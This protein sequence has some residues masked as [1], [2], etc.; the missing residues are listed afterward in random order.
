MISIPNTI[1]LKDEKVLDELDSSSSAHT[2]II[3]CFEDSCE[4][5]FEQEIGNDKNYYA[6][7]KKHR[8]LCFED[9][10]KWGFEKGH[11]WHEMFF[12]DENGIYVCSNQINLSDSRFGRIHFGE[13]T[14]EM[15][16]NPI[17]FCE[18]VQEHLT[19]KPII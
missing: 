1:T 18:L 5:L 19:L 15:G 7:C 11:F 10:V 13:L 8:S 6:K 2:V 17:K 12:A 16:K 9:M 3:E 4:T 14:D